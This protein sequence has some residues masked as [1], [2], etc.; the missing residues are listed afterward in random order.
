MQAFNNAW[1]GYD[2]PY[3]EIENQPSV[4]A[5]R[6]MGIQ[7]RVKL[8]EYHVTVAHFKDIDLDDLTSQVASAAE[9]FGDDLAESEFAFNGFGQIKNTEGRYVYFSPD[10]QR[11][12]E[13]VFLKSKLKPEGDLHLSIGGQDPFTPEKPNMHE[14]NEPFSV[15]GRLV[16]VGNDGK[17][18]RK[19]IWNSKTRRFDSLDASPVPAPQ[20]PMPPQ[21]VHT[22]A[23]FPK[24]QADTAVAVYLLTRFGEKQFPGISKANI[25]FWTAAP[26]DKTPERYEQ[27]GYLLLDL[28]GRFDHHRANKDSGQRSD[29]LSTIIA[30]ALG[31][32][33]SPILKKVLAWAKRDDLEGKGTISADAIDRAFGLSGILMNLNREFADQPEKT[34]NMLITIINV[35]VSEEYRRHIELPQ[36]WERLQSEGKAVPFEARQGSADLKCILVHSDTQALAGFLRAAHKFDLVVVRRST[37][38]LSVVT[39]QERSLDFRPVIT[40][41][42]VMEALKSGVPVNPTDPNLSLPGKFPGIDEWYYDDAANTLQNGGINPQGIPASKLSDEEIITALVQ[43]LPRGVIGSL[44]RQKEKELS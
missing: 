14:L 41:L 22:I 33:Q 10:L 27:E 31:M 32:E 7:K 25:V 19:F 43:G 1:I 17:T 2:L 39:R 8:P 23:I 3:D 38:H 40:S 37:G 12:S 29:C 30:R 13:A 36:E 20:P 4:K 44:K 16:F 21:A 15:R 42:R 28:G 6:Q 24:I 34:L 18:F 11:A 9:A 35:H 5:I 26:T